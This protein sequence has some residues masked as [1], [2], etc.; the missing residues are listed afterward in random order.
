MWTEGERI[1]HLNSSVAILFLLVKIDRSTVKINTWV[2]VLLPTLFCFHR[3]CYKQLSKN[4]QNIRNPIPFWCKIKSPQQNHTKQKERGLPGV[5]FTSNTYTLKRE[6]LTFSRKISRHLSSF[7][8][9]LLIFH[10]SIHI[11]MRLKSSSGNPTALPPVFSHHILSEIFKNKECLRHVTSWYFSSSPFP[12]I[13]SARS[14]V[15][16]FRHFLFCL[17]LP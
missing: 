15:R 16:C 12:T 6:I 1:S 5:N 4:A 2:S 10:Y 9:S 8:C 7:N 3:L 17:L 11:R 13:R 14:V